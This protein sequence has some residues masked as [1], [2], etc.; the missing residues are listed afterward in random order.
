MTDDDNTSDLALETSF[1]SLFLNEA[2]EKI[3][4][5][6]TDECWTQDDVTSAL[7]QTA[8]LS[9][10]S[11]AHAAE[12]YGSER[13]VESYP[14]DYRHNCPWNDW[15]PPSVSEHVFLSD[16]RSNKTLQQPEKILSSAHRK[17]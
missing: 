16:Y 9:Y 7:L 11:T 8:L 17:Q 2:L 13:Y 5:R 4:S 1:S 14:E 10:R 3:R 6:A 12:I 15:V